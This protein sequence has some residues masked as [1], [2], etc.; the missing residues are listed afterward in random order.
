MTLAGNA[1][2]AS[3]PMCSPSMIGMPSALAGGRLSM[4]STTESAMRRLTGEPFSD[5]IIDV[6]PWFLRNGLTATPW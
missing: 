4:I 3:S 6:P 1:S 5:S 2:A